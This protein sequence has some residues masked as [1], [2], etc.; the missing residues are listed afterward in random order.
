MCVCVCVRV[1]V[2]VRACVHV[3]VYVCVYVCVCVC[4]CVCKVMNSKQEVV[5]NGENTHTFCSNILSERLH[6]GT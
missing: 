4:V 5:K 2:H 3:C 6:T 1:R